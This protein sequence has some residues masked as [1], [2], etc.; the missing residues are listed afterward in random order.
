M[1]RRRID[2]G[3]AC[4]LARRREGRRGDCTADRRFVPLRVALWPAWEVGRRSF[5]GASAEA[6]G[7]GAPLS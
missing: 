6:G 5:A 7:D 3:E 2:R 4:G 1:R